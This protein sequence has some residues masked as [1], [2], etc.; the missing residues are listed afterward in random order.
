M[1]RD[2]TPA[3][4]NRVGQHPKTGQWTRSPAPGLSSSTGTFA[5]AAWRNEHEFVERALRATFT[6]RW[7]ESGASAPSRR[8]G[9]QA[10]DIVECSED[11]SDLGA[12]RVVGLDVHE[13][14]RSV[15]VDDEHGGPRQPCGAFG[16]DL[17]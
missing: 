14:H 4:R 7:Q 5:K 13:T 16:V 10:P 9:V 8:S 17:G 12:G 2:V 15:L 1:S 3:D 11:V 6:L